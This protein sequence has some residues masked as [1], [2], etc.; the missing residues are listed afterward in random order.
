VRAEAPGDASMRYVESSALLAALLEGDV[1]ARR[2]M[3]ADGPLVT[4]ALTF[5]EVHRGI[6]R[7]KATGR[8]TDIEERAAVRAVRRFRRQCFVVD[9]S[10]AVLV[11]AGRRFPVEPVRTLDAVH[12][13]TL[14]LLEEAP[15]LLTVLT[16]DARVRE[17]AVA[18]GYAV[19]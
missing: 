8:L 7:A 4:S 3:Q 18:L 5:A 10:D 19:Q 6:V 17:N 13:A 11:R 16:R 14:E 9:V 2:A 12:L 15:P 1:E